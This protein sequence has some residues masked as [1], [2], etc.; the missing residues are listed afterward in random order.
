M[1][2]QRR[3]AVL[4][5]ARF[6]IVVTL[7]LGTCDGHAG[8][9]GRDAEDGAAAG[10][11][12]SATV[13]DLLAG[14]TALGA[15]Y[16]LDHLALSGVVFKQNLGRSAMTWSWYL[17]DDV[18]HEKKAQCDENDHQDGTGT[19]PGRRL[20]RVLWVLVEPVQKPAGYEAGVIEA[21]SGTVVE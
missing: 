21:T 9:L 17:P 7:A 4:A 10:A 12:Q 11:E 8:L 3:S 15:P 6:L 1:F 13:L 5:G 19:E 16:F 14:T 20:G 18:D 2:D